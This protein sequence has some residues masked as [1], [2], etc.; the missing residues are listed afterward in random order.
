MQIVPPQILSCLN[1]SSTR[2]L[3]LQC[4]KKL[5]N[6]T[7]LTEYSL[8]SRSTS[9]TSTKSLLQAKIQPFSGEDVEKIPLR[10]HQNT[11]FQVKIPFFSGDGTQP[12]PQRPR[13]IPP[14][15]KLSP[16]AY[17]RPHQ[18]FWFRPSVPQNSSQINATAYLHRSAGKRL[19]SD[20]LRCSQLL[21]QRP[22]GRFQLSSASHLSNTSILCRK[23]WCVRR[24]HCVV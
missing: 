4:S 22:G 5:T 19:L 20:Q 2:L 17:T 11:L 3:A 16:H 14:L 13:L 10:M 18:A 7:T 1:I 8:F 24:A 15:G 12:P 21:M 6:P 23:A 9:S